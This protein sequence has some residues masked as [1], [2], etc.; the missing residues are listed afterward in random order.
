MPPRKKNTTT[1]P[2]LDDLLE[3]SGK[4]QAPQVDEPKP[5]EEQ[6]TEETK[7]LTPEE[8]ELEALRA[9]VAA[10]RAQQA[11]RSS[12]ASARVVPE[13]ELS[14]LERE[15][16]RL[17]DELA[18]SIGR[19][20]DEKFEDV[21]EDGEVLVLHIL[22]DGFTRLGHVWYRGQE[23]VI[24]PKAFEDTKNRNGV[25]W[26]SMTEDQQIEKWGEVYFRK[27]PWPG[28]REYEDP[29]LADKS[30]RV[31]APVMRTVDA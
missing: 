19:K 7:A 1:Q 18:R 16:R 23:I 26:T 30:I 25:S 15:N 28:K 10:L 3:D 22:K 2:D 20:L 17:R 9:E 27:G 29:A 6:E 24:G 4:P 13:E 8:L 5:D 31:Q 14:P 11:E 12:N 21:A